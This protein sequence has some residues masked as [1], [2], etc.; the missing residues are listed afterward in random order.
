MIAR[1][2][3]S[4]DSAAQGARIAADSLFPP[5]RRKAVVVDLDGT[6]WKGVVGE[7][8]AE[9]IWAADEGFGAPYHAFGRFLIKLRSEGTL[10]AYCSKNAPEDALAGLTAPGL[11][12]RAEDFDTGVASWDPK[13]K[14]LALVAA[15]LGFSPDA[16]VFVDDSPAEL[17]EVAHNMPDVEILLAPSSAESWPAF[18]TAVQTLVATDRVGVEDRARTGSGERARTAQF[19]AAVL[20]GVG[21]Y[22]HLRD[23]ELRQSTCRR[24]AGV[25]RTTELLN[26]TNQFNLTTER[27]RQDE[28]AARF[29]APDA[30]CWSWALCDRFGEY[31]TVA[32]MLAHEVAPLYWC[33]E[34][35]ATSCR[36]LA[37]GVDFAILQRV[38]VE[39]NAAR[40]EICFRRS[41]RDAP[42]WDFIRT[43]GSDPQAPADEVVKPYQV[44][45][46][47]LEAIAQRGRDESGLVADVD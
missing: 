25:A 37:R 44:D 47:A 42:A 9:G 13:S 24:A 11:A 6:L 31:G 1:C 15:E 17:A 41:N 22:G 28:L 46:A 29:F 19:G 4:V 40:L 36:A 2:P 35:M 10:L 30:L 26:K 39:R 5:L 12:L 32:V 43:I 14:G 45:M 16:L 23:F 8:G 20:G 33:V 3:L 7:D 27:V 21:G 18:F 38:R 34:N